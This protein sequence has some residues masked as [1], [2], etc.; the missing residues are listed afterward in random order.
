[1]IEFIFYDIHT[2]KE[3]QTIVTLFNFNNIIDLLQNEDSD[4]RREVLNIIFLYICLDYPSATY[5]L[6]ETNFLNYLEDLKKEGNYSVQRYLIYIIGM[7]IIVMDKD[8]YTKLDWRFILEFLV[9]SLDGGSDFDILSLFQNLI[10]FLFYK[11]QLV[12][13]YN[14]PTISEILFDLSID[15]YLEQFLNNPFITE[16][17]QNIIEY[18]NQ[19][20]TPKT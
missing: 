1:L 9:R 16:D 8:H 10:F 2:Q 17:Q 6:C 11:Q 4:I 3:E 13:N 20:L 18:I 12:P 14:F 15:T 19:C 5:L 7:A